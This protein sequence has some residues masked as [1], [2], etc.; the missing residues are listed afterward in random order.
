MWVKRK[1]KRGIK[2]DKTERVGNKYKEGGRMRHHSPLIL[3]VPST[4][5]HGVTSHYTAVLALPAMIQLL[6]CLSP[7][8]IGMGIAF[9]NA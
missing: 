7:V 4:K 6:V 1:T 9:I 3:F 5:L 8:Q 2:R